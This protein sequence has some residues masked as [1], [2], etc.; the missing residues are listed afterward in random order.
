MNRLVKAA[1]IVLGLSFS[2]SSQALVTICYEYLNRF[3]RVIMSYTATDAATWDDFIFWATV[4]EVDTGHTSGTYDGGS[5]TPGGGGRSW[6]YYGTNYP[7]HAPNGIWVTKG[8]GYLV[9]NPPTPP[10]SDT[11][12]ETIIIG[13]PV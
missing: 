11:C 13:I 6:I 8:L 2:S 3:P 10:T 1:G 7:P 4:E 5:L 9:E 12:Q